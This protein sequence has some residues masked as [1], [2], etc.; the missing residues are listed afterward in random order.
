MSKWGGL[1]LLSSLKVTGNRTNRYSTYEFLLAY[2]SNYVPILYFAAFVRYSRR[3]EPLYPPHVW[4]VHNITVSDGDRT[5]N[6]CEAWNRRFVSLVGHKNP[7]VWTV[8]ELQRADAAE[9]VT[10]LVQLSAGRLQPKACP[11]SYYKIQ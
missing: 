8:I 7:S 5:N 2:H 10:S 9:A 4:N 3:I 6:Y 11:Q 1:G